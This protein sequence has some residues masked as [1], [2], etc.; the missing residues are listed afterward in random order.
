MGAKIYTVFLKSNPDPVITVVLKLTLILGNPS[1]KR[2]F[3][4][5]SFSS[6]KFPPFFSKKK[7]VFKMHFKPF[8]AILDHVFFSTFLGGYPRQKF[9]KKLKKKM[10]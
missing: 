8:Q 3:R 7:V 6:G 1:K 9:K 5:G 10:V 2:V 4:T